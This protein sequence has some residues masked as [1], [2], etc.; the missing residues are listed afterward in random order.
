MAKLITNSE[1]IQ[2]L[3]YKALNSKCNN[4]VFS[5][6][7][8]TVL[9]EIIKNIQ[10]ICQLSNVSDEVLYEINRLDMINMIID[11]SKINVEDLLNETL[12]MLEISKTLKLDDIKSLLRFRGILREYNQ[13]VQW[14]ILNAQNLSIEDQMLLN[15]LFV[16]NTYFFNTNILISNSDLSTYQ[17]KN[18]IYLDDRENYEKIKISRY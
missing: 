18:G 11:I 3:N 17:L 16:L 7:P 9:P 8:S 12:R 14:I 10:P 1:I 5:D 4:Y 13:A 2:T 6:I 15:E